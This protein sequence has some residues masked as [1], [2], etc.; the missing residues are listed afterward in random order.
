MYIPL[1]FEGALQSCLYASGGYEQGFFISA[2][3][4]YAFHVFS[5][6]GSQQ[7]EVLAGTLNNAKIAVVGGGGGGAFAYPAGGG[8]GGG[9]I[10]QDN[11][12]LYGGIYN[13]NVGRGGLEGNP[14][15][16]TSIGG[17]NLSLSVGGGNPGVGNVGGNSGTPTT[18]LG[19]GSTGLD[20]GGGGG[21]AAGNA[22]AFPSG[23]FNQGGPGIS[24]SFGGDTG[25]MPFPVGY[26]N[27][28]IL[29]SGGNG[30]GGPYADPFSLYGRGGKGVNSN[31]QPGPAQAGRD[32]AVIIQYPIND[33]CKNFFNE[34]GS[35][36][37]RQVIIDV[38]DGLNFYPDV[39][40]SYLYTPCGTNTFVSGN[41]E[42]HWPTTLCAASNSWYW[43]ERSGPI[44]GSSAGVANSGAE[45]FSASY[46][47]ETCV[48]QSFP[49]TCNSN[50]YTFYNTGGGTDTI[51]WVPKNAINLSYTTL[52]VG[53]I[54]Y[55]CVSSGS[56]GSIGSY[57]YGGSEVIYLTASCQ[58]TAITAS[59]S[60]GFNFSYAEYTYTPCGGPVNGAS[61][62]LNKSVLGAVVRTANIGCVDT[63]FTG[64]WVYSGTIPSTTIN[65]TGSCLNDYISTGSC[66]CTTTY[67]TC[68]CLSY[69]FTAGNDLPSTY[70]ATNIMYCGSGVSGSIDIPI[71]TSKTLCVVSQSAPYFGL[72][73]IG[74]SIT[75]LGTCT[76]G[77]CP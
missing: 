22:Y 39:S 75:L 37:C 70:T 41:L 42:S 76:T 68:S 15:Q 1:T 6:T 31:T 46:G 21:G 16:G 5:Q 44:S 53:A 4:Q 13:I 59:W 2:S 49:P 77:S 17:T 66:G 72:T 40:G 62:R 14:G 8:G 3:Q 29:G 58:S 7:F 47:V 56:I 52:G 12:T 27:T 60:S 74:A 18:F 65:R 36:D 61:I 35:C 45:C 28:K 64:S 38:T 34:T 32:G 50:I 54:S 69:L 11:V 23:L 71:N 43:F 55:Q 24:S 26:G 9:V 57:P 67:N 30:S 19:V 25:G 63:T 20:R 33:Y 51:F 73:G 48:T 10:V